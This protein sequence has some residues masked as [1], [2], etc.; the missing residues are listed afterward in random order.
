MG[1]FQKGRSR[2]WLDDH[3]WWVCVVEFQ[4]SGW[5]RGSYLNV[6]CMWLW[7][8]KGYLS[9]D[10]GSRV[11]SFS[12]FQDHE[13]FE[14][15]ALR[16]AVR[17]AEEVERY[18]LLF[19]TVRRVCEFYLERPVMAPGHWQNFHAAV[20]CA[21][22]GKPDD[23]VR[24]FDQ[25]LVPQIDGPEWLILAQADA[26]RLKELSAHTVEFRAAVAGR[27]RRARE[28]QKLPPSMVVDF[29]IATRNWENQDR[30]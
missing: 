23:A 12:K 3:G 29:D 17:A 27:V 6:G 25:F 5:S 21:M 9:F 16:L 13:Q 7:C 14:N 26:Q 20:A 8:E 28:L 15:E 4:P 10:E 2:T 22:A 11:E 24:F 18:R 30:K 19:P 1:L